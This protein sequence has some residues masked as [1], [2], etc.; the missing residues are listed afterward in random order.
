MIIPSKRLIDCEQAHISSLGQA[1][2]LNKLPK[3]VG[4]SEC[5]DFGV[6]D[7]GMWIDSDPMKIVNAFF[8]RSWHTLWPGELILTKKIPNLLF[9][10]STC[11]TRRTMKDPSFMPS[12]NCDPSGLKATLRTASSMLQRAIKAWSAR[13]HSLSAVPRKKQNKTASH[14]HQSRG[15][16]TVY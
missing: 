6:I 10:I 14:S 8:L 5:L 16:R 4:F 13:L 3:N 2:L 12:A 1:V 9:H 7:R 15:W 11:L